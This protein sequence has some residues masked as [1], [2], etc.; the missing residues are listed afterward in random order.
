MST[1]PVHILLLGGNGRTGQLVLAEALRRSHPV[2]ALVRNATS[3]TPT[4]E[5]SIVE[6]TPLNKPDIEKAVASIP[7]SHSIVI[8]STLSQTRVSGNP[9]SSTTSPKRLMADA[10]DNVIAISKSN[11][12]IEKLVVMSM[13]G[14][15]N[16]FGNLMFLMRWIMNTSNM[17]VTLEDHNL[18]DKAVKGSGLNFVTVRSAMLKG[19]EATA[20]MDLGDDGEKA[21]MMP[22]VSRKSVAGFL[23][24]AAEQSTW[25]GRTPVISN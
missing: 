6:G 25:D 4:P 24:D 1:Q 2:T 13:F 22:T 23:L 19:E 7:L 20:V 14:A 21:G 10:I 12:R 18:V 11:S 3:L 5:L 8:I 15:G 16:S 17:D 9:W